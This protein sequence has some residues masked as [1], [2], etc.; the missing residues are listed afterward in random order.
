MSIMNTL[1]NTQH[2]KTGYILHTGA[3]YFCATNCYSTHKKLEGLN[4][5]TSINFVGKTS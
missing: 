3:S 4:W 2:R 5:K 1:A